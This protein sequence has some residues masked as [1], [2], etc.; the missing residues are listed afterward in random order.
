MDTRQYHVMT[1]Y[2]M[3]INSG[4]WFQTSDEQALNEIVAEVKRV[5][6]SCVLTTA[7]M[8]GKKLPCL[9]KLK[10]QDG[11]LYED[12]RGWLQQAGWE[13]ISDGPIYS[14]SGNLSH[15]ECQFRRRIASAITQNSVRTVIPD[16]GDQL[17][18]IA[19]LH[20]TGAITDAEYAAAKRKLL[21][22]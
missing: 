11:N 10:N 20:K 18:K 4:L 17:E 5:V 9:K 6:P 14:S 13:L 21:G 16:I 2:K 1:M 8:N 22:T 7:W 3:G 19:N 12:I 15:Y